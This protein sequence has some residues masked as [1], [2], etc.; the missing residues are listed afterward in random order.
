MRALRAALLPHYAFKRVEPF[1]G[2]LRID[3]RN[4]LHVHGST[5]VGLS[6]SIW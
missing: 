3:V 5:F 1:L 2:F 4:I 6:V